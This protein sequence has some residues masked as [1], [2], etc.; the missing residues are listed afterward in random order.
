[1]SNNPARKTLPKSGTIY[2]QN[3]FI[4]HNLAC[5]IHFLPYAFLKKWLPIFI[6]FKSTL[7]RVIPSNRKNM[8]VIYYSTTPQKHPNN[9]L[10]PANYLQPN[11]TKWKLNESQMEAK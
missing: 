4:V 1:M 2:S 8:L 7:F 11:G 9:T 10:I 3:G 6:K 5:H